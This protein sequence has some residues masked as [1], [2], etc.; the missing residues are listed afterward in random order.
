MLLSTNATRGTTS[1]VRVSSPVKFIAFQ[2]IT[3]RYLTGTPVPGIIIF[4]KFS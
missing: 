1:R 2:Y 3:L 4:E